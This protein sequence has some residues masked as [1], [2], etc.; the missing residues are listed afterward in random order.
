[1]Y[2]GREQAVV[3]ATKAA[4][5]GPL[6][7]QPIFQALDTGLGAA[8]RMQTTSLG[9]QPPV[10]VG[11]TTGARFLALTSPYSRLDRGTAK[12]I[13][14]GY[15]VIMAYDLVERL[16]NHHSTSS[17]TLR[18]PRGLIFLDLQTA[19]DIPNGGRL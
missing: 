4:A 16:A 15:L 9:S 13:R 1:M 2:K 12:G 3:L 10:P 7:L 8:A 14:R 17:P 5:D 19:Y 11:L 18:P 6:N